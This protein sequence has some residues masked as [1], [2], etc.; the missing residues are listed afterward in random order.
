MIVKIN[1]GESLEIVE[2]VFANIIS[3]SGSKYYSW[4]EMS[5][6]QRGCLISMKKEIATLYAKYKDC[7]SG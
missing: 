2:G 5:E 4:D 1:A 3:A 7:L 6:A